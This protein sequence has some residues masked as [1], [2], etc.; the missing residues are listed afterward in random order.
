[1]PADDE[2]FEKLSSR[3]RP[4]LPGALA[5]F[6]GQT[7]GSHYQDTFHAPLSDELQKLVKALDMAERDEGG[8]DI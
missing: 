7:L 3:D 5:S 6:L 8:A 4:H 2:G 1:M